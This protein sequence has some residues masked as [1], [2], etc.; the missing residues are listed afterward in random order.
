MNE[1]EED[2]KLASVF[3]G[4]DPGKSG[5]MAVLYTPGDLVASDGTVRR[6]T[7]MD[8]V[9]VPFGELAFL[10]ELRMAASMMNA[11]CPVKAVVEHVGG[12]PGQSAPASFNFGDNF[13]FTRGLLAALGI[14]YELVRPQKWKK[15][16]SCT[17]DKNTAI[18]VA[19]RLFPGVDLKRTPRCQK[20][21]DGH[22]EAL[23]MAEYARR[24]LA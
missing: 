3:I 12:M 15:E 1:M 22:A 14:P 2:R 23:L 21:D 13:G 8:L 6:R 16:F 20:D 11:G 24:R 9:L 4:V 17:S 5:S 10:K 19:K 18:D 7:G